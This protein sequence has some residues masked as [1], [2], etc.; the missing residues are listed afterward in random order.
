MN[1]TS[2]VCKQC[3]TGYCCPATVTPDNCGATHQQLGSGATGQFLKGIGPEL[4]E[5][6]KNRSG[7]LAVRCDWPPFTSQEI[8]QIIEGPI[9]A[10]ES[11]YQAEIKKPLDLREIDYFALGMA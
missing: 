9:A 10:A 5:V 2:S 8:N 1:A 7:I 4:Y 3:P 11:V 6:P